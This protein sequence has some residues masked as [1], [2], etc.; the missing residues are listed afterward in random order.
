M[1]YTVEQITPD[2]AGVEFFLASYKPFRLQALQTDPQFFGSTY[3]TEVAKEDEFWRRRVS[4]PEAT[5]FVAVQAAPDRRILSSLTLIRGT[6]PSPVLAMAAGLVP[7]ERDKDSRTLL[8]WAVNGVYTARDARRRGI[9]RAVFARAL[10]FSFETAAAEGKS[11][12]VSILVREENEVAIG[13]YRRMGFVD[14]G[15]AEVDGNTVLYMFKGRE[16]PNLDSA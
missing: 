4:R 6:Q 1:N 16:E 13:M 3:E 5:T 8:H 11:C 10:A 14:V 7:E 9:A 2:E 12:L 15:Y